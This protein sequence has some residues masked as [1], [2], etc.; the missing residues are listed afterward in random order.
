VS[1]QNRGLATFCELTCITQ[2]CN[3]WC[4]D[5]STITYC[6]KQHHYSVPVSK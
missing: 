5:K 6:P 1:D 3:T 4:C 2:Q